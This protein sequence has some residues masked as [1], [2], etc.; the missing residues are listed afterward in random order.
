[1]TL[2]CVLTVLFLTDLLCISWE[3]N[4]LVLH[5]SQIYQQLTTKV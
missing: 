3:F 4:S 5:V 1:M 2:A